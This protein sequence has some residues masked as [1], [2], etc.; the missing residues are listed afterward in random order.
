ARM[1]LVG[2]EHPEL[3]VQRMIE[4][5]GLG[6]HVRVLGYAPIEEFVEYIGACDICL[7]L[8][9][10]TVGET[11]GTLLRALGLGKAVIVSDIGSFADLPD[12]ICLKAPVDKS[13]VDFIVE[14]INLLIER[15]EIR[16]VIG[17]RARE[18][19]ARECSWDLVGKLLAERLRDI[20]SG[21]PR[22]QSSTEEPTGRSTDRLHAAR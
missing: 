11:S 21:M 6:N 16:A 1:I 14:Y 20:H 19:V 4:E 8:R 13:E 17:E 9:Y 18:Y 3:P 12:S 7:N 22:T 10:P 2:E 5:L 15:P